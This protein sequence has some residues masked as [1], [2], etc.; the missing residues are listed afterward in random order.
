MG[1]SA[2]IT[3]VVMHTQTVIDMLGYLRE[4]P[5]PLSLCSGAL[6]GHIK[7]GATEFTLYYLYASTKTDEKCIHQ[8]SSHNPAVSIRRGAFSLNEGFVQAAAS[9]PNIVLFGG[10]SGAL[11]GT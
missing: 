11:T 6:C 1:W 7:N 5:S 3:P 9:D 2:S 4:N 8:A 10:L